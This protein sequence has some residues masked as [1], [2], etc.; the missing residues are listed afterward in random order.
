MAEPRSIRKPDQ[1]ICEANP[2]TNQPNGVT[3]GLPSSHFL[4]LRAQSLKLGRKPDPQSS[5]KSQIKHLSLSLSLY[6]SI[7]EPGPSAV[8]VFQPWLHLA[9][10]GESTLLLLLR[11]IIRL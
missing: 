2:S 10:L 6:N 4:L 1:L 3:V 5:P 8:D 7:L 9:S 11:L